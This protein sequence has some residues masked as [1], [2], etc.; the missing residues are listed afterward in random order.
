M[1]YSPFALYSG[2]AA[3]LGIVKYVFTAWPPY[4]GDDL[5]DHYYIKQGIDLYNSR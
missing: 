5:E 3:K 2:G 1:G 4:W